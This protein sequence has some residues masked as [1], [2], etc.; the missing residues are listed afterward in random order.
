MR[1]ACTSTA[2]HQ[3]CHAS[4]HP[5]DVILRRSFT[6]PSTTLAVIEGLH[7]N[8][9]NSIHS[10]TIQL[11]LIPSF[12]DQLSAVMRNDLTAQN[13]VVITERL[14][15]R[16]FVDDTRAIVEQLNVCVMNKASKTL[17]V[18]W[19]NALPRQLRCELKSFERHLHYDINKHAFDQIGHASFPLACL[20][21]YK[22]QLIV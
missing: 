10:P 18:M 14:S 6:R 12:H 11:P 3:K 15:F 22:F 1:R 21:C 5:P 17:F 9:A 4:K 20:S 2:V 19:L 16:P 8:K 13:V 7:G